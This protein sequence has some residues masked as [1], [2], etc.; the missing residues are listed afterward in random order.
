M[1]RGKERGVDNIEYSCPHEFT[2]INIQSKINSLTSVNYSFFM[3]YKTIQ[4]I[5]SGTDPGLLLKYMFKTLS[6]LII[7]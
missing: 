5:F 2:L 1:E 4:C 7:I 3:F 6:L